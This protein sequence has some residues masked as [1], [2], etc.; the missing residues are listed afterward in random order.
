MYKE[1]QVCVSVWPKVGGLSYKKK[2]KK[3]TEQTQRAG[4][5]MALAAFT[6]TPT[7]WL[8]PVGNVTAVKQSENSFIPPID[9]SGLANAAPSLHSLSNSLNHHCSL[10][11]PLS[12][13]G[14]NSESCFNKQQST[15]PTHSA[16]W[17]LTNLM[18]YFIQIEDF[19]KDFCFSAMMS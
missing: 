16:F 13:H 15:N 6:Q 2:K 9:C 4:S 19:V 12:L 17:R 14:A 7:T 5:S 3:N 18:N 11:L 8:L 10:S 1:L